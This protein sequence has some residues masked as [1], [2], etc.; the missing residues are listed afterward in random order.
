M[1]RS[2]P[3]L[4]VVPSLREAWDDA[5]APG[6]NEFCPRLGNHVAFATVVVP[7]RGQANDLSAL[8]CKGYSH[9]GLQFVTAAGLRALLARDD[10][11]PH[12]SRNI[13]ACSSQLLRAKWKIANV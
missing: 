2:R 6:S 8:D 9:F 7:T 11:T 12:A 5:I 10:A 3:L 13:S 1:K 4:L